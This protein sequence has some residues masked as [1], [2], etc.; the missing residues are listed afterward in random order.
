MLLTLNE[1]R[2]ALTEQL[3]EIRA[4]TGD[5]KK[6]KEIR[7]ISSEFCKSIKLE[8][9]HYKDLGMKPMLGTFI[10]LPEPK[11][12]EQQPATA[13]EGNAHENNRP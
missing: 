11:K 10:S 13:D 8:S 9:Q 6:S 1:I 5:L 3:R 7:G 4:G 12:E 2:E